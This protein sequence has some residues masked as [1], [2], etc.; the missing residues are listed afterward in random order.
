MKKYFPHDAEPL[1]KLFPANQDREV[2]AAL[3]RAVTVCVFVDSARF[4]ARA[5]SRGRSNAYLYRF[6]RVHPWAK[7]LKLGAFHAS[8]IPFV[9]GK[10][11]EKFGYGP[12]DHE[13][14]KTMS[15]CWVRFARTGNPNGGAL[16]PWP[17]YDPAADP[18]MEFGDTVR[19]GR[20]FEKPA[21][22]LLDKIRA[23]ALKEGQRE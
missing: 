3:N 14:A 5:M 6:T 22:D 12:L 9:F 13:L 16:P 10:L 8:E 23:E 1:L 20:E 7:A 15:A 18:Y 2:R 11:P 17:A 21:C 4:D 19:V